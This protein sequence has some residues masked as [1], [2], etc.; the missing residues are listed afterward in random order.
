MRN[1]TIIQQSPPDLIQPRGDL[2]LFRF[3]QLIWEKGLEVIL[4]RSIKCPCKQKGGD[5]LTSCRNCLGTGEIFVNP[6]QTRMF[7]SSIN[8]NTKFSSWSE[9]KLGTVSVSAMYIDKLNFMDRITILN[10]ESCYSQVLYPFEFKQQLFAYTTYDIQSADALFVFEGEDQKLTKLV[11]DTDFTVQDNMILLDDKFKN[12]T[13]LSL[14]M[15]YRHKVQFHVIDIVHD[16]RNSVV[17]G[18]D[19][20]EKDIKLPINA[21]ARRSHYCLDSENFAG[22]L[23]FDNS[24]TV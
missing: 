24:F 18:N 17:I 7:V 4:E 16:V 12:K 3:N 22:T 5:N 14:S 19:G 9:T 21:I 6:I 2:E 11:E 10:S 8:A 1:K 15:L 23:L 20:K 13:Y